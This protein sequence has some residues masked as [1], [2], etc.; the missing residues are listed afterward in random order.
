MIIYLDKQYHL[1]EDEVHMGT[2]DE[3]YI[4]GREETFQF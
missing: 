4:Y 3:V 2:I 1:I